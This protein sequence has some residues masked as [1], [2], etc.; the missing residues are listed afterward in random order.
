MHIEFTKGIE[1]DLV[2]IERDDGTVATTTVSKKGRIPHDAI[3]LIVEESMGFRTA[4]WGRVAAGVHP[5]IV[6]SIAKAGG[7]ASSQRARQ[8]DPGI[9][10]LIQAERLVECFEAEM[11]SDPADA[12]TFFGVFEAACAQSLV[13]ADILTEEQIQMLRVQLSRFE[14][15]WRQLAIGERVALAW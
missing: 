13:P 2:S 12:A 3:H 4:F 15:Q 11:W 5:E 6:A 14:N 9:V 10:E 1:G 7:H 8:L